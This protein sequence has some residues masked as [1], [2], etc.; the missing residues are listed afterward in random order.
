MDEKELCKETLKPYTLKEIKRG[1]R[2]IGRPFVYLSELS[3][4]ETIRRI[5]LHFSDDELGR[6]LAE[7]GPEAEL[8]KKEK[9]DDRR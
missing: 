4:E 3:R 2:A 8:N 1:L 6:L 9:Q 5:H 7:V